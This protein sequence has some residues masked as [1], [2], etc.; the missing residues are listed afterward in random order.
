MPTLFSEAYG[1]TQN[2]G[3]TR[4]IAQRLFSEGYK[5]SSSPEDADTIIIGTCGVIET[6]TTKI[7]KRM[8]KLTEIVP[9]ARFLIAGCMSPLMEDEIRTI[10]PDAKLLSIDESWRSLPGNRTSRFHGCWFSRLNVSF[11]R[12]ALL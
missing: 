6:T 10:I 3:E 1:C 9:D 8:R 4:E 7:M 5:Y 11:F 12:L 2:Q